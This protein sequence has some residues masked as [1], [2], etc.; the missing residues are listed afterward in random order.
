[1]LGI[2]NISTSII[3]IILALLIRFF[4]LKNLIAGYNTLSKEEKKKYNEKKLVQ[5]IIN[6]LIIS[7]L[8]ILVG[9]IPSLIKLKWE[10][11][12][13]IASWI[14]FTLFIFVS[15]IFINLNKKI[16]K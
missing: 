10:I 12:F 13:F 4:N 1:M 7:G 2:I 6:M 5:Y 9:A 8:I 16:K 11:E 14:V 15:V 3:I